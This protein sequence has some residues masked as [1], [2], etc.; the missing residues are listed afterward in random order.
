MPWSRCPERDSGQ[1]EAQELLEGGCA[2]LGSS[3]GG[4]AE[5]AALATRHEPAKLEHKLSARLWL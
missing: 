4:G 1:F 3:Q 2:A 5:P